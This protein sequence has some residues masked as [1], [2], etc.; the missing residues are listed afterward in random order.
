MEFPPAPVAPVAAIEGA[1]ESKEDVPFSQP[2]AAMMEPTQVAQMGKPPRGTSRVSRAFGIARNEPTPMRSETAPMT[3][4]R[5]LELQLAADLGISPDDLMRIG[6]TAPPRR[7]EAAPAAAAAVR[8]PVPAV[9]SRLG[10]AGAGAVPGGT[11]FAGVGDGTGAGAAE[12]EK[13]PPMGG[14][15][16]PMGGAGAP[17]GGAGVP[18]SAG[19]PP[20]LPPMSAEQRRLYD[21]EMARLRKAQKS[22]SDTER[23]K[24]ALEKAFR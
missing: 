23:R 9:F 14:A 12:K 16:A 18:G 7:M 17:M 2:A 6:E 21:N 22:L 8:P 10:G 19:R 24:L 1:A 20:V 4:G 15:G 5:A 13:R 11:V 3:A